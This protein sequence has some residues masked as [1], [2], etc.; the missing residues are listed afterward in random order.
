M[1]VS[2]FLIGVGSLC[3]GSGLTISGIAPVGMITASSISFLSSISTLI[4]NEYFSKLKIRYTKLRDLINVTTLLFEKTLK[5][6]MIVK[7]IAEKEGEK[8]R[9][10]YNQYLNKQDDFKKSTQFKVEEVSGNI[11]PKD[12]ILL[13]QITKLNSF[14]SQNDVNL[15]ININFKLFKPKQKKHI[16][17]QPS[18]PLYY[19]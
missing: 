6:S 15:Y 17:Y 4:T 11:I 18:A 7:K 19:E 8:L 12:T 14:F 13:E 1:I 2:E 9:S 16:D 5:E 3:V 10:V